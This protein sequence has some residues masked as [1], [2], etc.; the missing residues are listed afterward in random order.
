MNHTSLRE[1]TDMSA[2]HPFAPELERIR[3]AYSKRQSRSVY[4]LFEPAQMLAIQER[5]RRLLRMLSIHGIASLESTKILE[6]G[7]GTGMWLREFVRWG[8]RPENLYG[9]DLLAERIAEARRLCAPGIRLECG[10]ATQL[11]LGNAEFDFV[12]Q[13]TM[14][15]SILDSQVKMRIAGEMLRVLRPNGCIIWYDFRVNNPRN[16][17]VQG[18]KINEIRS[19]FPGCCLDLRKLTLAPPIARPVAR[20]SS[21]LHRV[22]SSIPPL[23]THYLVLIK[24]A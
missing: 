14:F 13:S 1:T 11:N 21:T 19:L 16:A 18:I 12:L 3:A 7:C 8:A 24:R 20:I 23:R 4:S 15:T 5:E 22:L 9:I 2:P 10:S 6:V 17:D